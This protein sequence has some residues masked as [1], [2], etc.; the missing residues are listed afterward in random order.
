[1][2]TLRALSLVV[3][4]TTVVVMPHSVGIAAVID[5]FSVCLGTKG[6]G[7]GAPSINFILIANSAGSFFQLTG[8]ATFSQAVSPPNGLVIYS[9]SGSAIT[10]ADGFWVSL[11]GTGYD[12]AKTVFLGTFGLQLSADPAKNTLTYAKQSLD[13]AAPQVVTAV[14]E[15]KPCP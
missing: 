3:F 2:K 1:M 4:V 5:P 6:G 14:P 11:V 8:Q 10:N 7:P 12:L 15:I 13:A 9:V